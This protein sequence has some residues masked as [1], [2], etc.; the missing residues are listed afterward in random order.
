MIAYTTTID[1]LEFTFSFE[2]TNERPWT[3]RSRDN[4]YLMHWADGETAEAALQAFAKT[5]SMDFDDLKA[6]LLDPDTRLPAKS[7]TE[8]DLG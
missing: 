2:A 3:A 6:R 4:G 5:S 1:H 8:R 7:L